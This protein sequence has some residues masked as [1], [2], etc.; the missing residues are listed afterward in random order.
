MP[1]Y[2]ANSDLFLFPFSYNSTIVFLNS[3]VYV[4]IF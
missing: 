3:S 4:L 2:L 1:Y